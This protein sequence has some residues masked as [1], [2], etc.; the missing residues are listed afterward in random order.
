MLFILFRK[1]RDYIYEK[2]QYKVFKRKEF[3]DIVHKKYFLCITL[4]GHSV[5]QITIEPGGWNG[6]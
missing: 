5:P 3:D 1:S 2:C 4:F 6:N